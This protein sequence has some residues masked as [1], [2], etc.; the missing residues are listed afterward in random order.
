MSPRNASKGDKVTITV[1]PDDGYVLK[2]LTATASNG[3]EIE[4][5][6]RADGRYTF[7]MPAGSVKV[8]ATWAIALRRLPD[9]ATFLL[10]PIMQTQ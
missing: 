5:T 4:L 3:D 6:K 8:K 9:S 7:T 10:M 1:N 2:D